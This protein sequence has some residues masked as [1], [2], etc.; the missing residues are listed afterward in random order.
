LDE[1]ETFRDMLRNTNLDAMRA[2]VT[3]DGIWTWSEFKQAM[4]GL[5]ALPDTPTDSLLVLTE[6]ALTYGGVSVD[7][8][9]V[10]PENLARV[11]KWESTYDK[12]PRGYIDAKVISLREITFR[13][14]IILVKLLYTH[15]SGLVTPPLPPL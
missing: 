6:H 5:L 8:H 13:E 1:V 10:K 15:M 4:D 12:D 3:E 11:D 2:W 7:A 14:H 9:I